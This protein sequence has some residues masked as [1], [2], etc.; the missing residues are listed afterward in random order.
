M[1][2]SELNIAI[3]PSSTAATHGVKDALILPCLAA[4][5]LDYPAHRVQK[6]TVED[7]FSMVH[8]STGMNEPVSPLCLSEIDIVAPHGRGNAA[9]IGWTGWRCGMTTTGCCGISSRRPSRAL[10]TSTAA[11][12][13]LRLP[14]RR[15]APPCCAGTPRAGRAEFRAS[16]LPDSIPPECTSHAEQMVDQPVLLLPG[17]RPTDQHNTTIYALD[18]RYRGIKG[19]ATW[20]S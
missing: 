4:P 9:A 8:A 13:A 20:S 19:D 7:T 3:A 6:I 17:L 14:S 15:T 1:R 5:E 12:R 11:S 16:R 18:D 2:R 10:A